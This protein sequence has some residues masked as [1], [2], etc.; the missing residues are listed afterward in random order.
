VPVIARTPAHE[1]RSRSIHDLTDGTIRG[2][3]MMAIEEIEDLVKLLIGHIG[4]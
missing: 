4:I 1:E 2:A 3:L